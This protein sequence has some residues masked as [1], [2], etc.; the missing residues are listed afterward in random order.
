MSMGKRKT[1]PPP[2]EET[3]SYGLIEWLRMHRIGL[4]PVYLAVPVLIMGILANVAVEVMLLAICMT[5]W[6]LGAGA[7]V[8]TRVPEGWRRLHWLTIMVSIN[9]WVIW[10]ATLSTANGWMWALGLLASGTTILAIPHWMDQ[11]KRT[12]VN[13]EGLIRHWPVRGARIGLGDT[14]LV[15]ITHTAVGWVGKLSWQPGMH[16]IKKVEKIEHE[17][18][19]ALDLPHN[20]LKIERDG[21][22]NHS[23]ILQVTLNDPHA[24]GIM[25]SPA[26]EPTEDGPRLRT[27]H[28]GDPIKIGIRADGTEKF[29]RIFKAG[30]GARN[31]LIAGTKG[32]GKSGLLNLIWTTMALCDDVVQWGIDLKG[33]VE[34]GPWEGV[35]DW[36][37][38]DYASAIKMIEAAE[39]IVERRGQLLKKYGWKSWQGSPEHPWL[40]ISI[41]EAASLLGKMDSKQLF[42]VEEIARKGR[43]VGV[44]LAIATQYAT[45]DA[46]GSSQIREQLD[47]AF[48]FRQQ[49]GSGESFVITVGNVNAEEIDSERPGTCYHQ[50]G[51]KLDR[52]PM[53]I[54]FVGDGSNG[55]R[56]TVKLIADVMRGETPE[57][58][59]D[60]IRDGIEKLEAYANRQEVTEMRDD[61]EMSETAEGDEQVTGTE[62]ETETV[63]PFETDGS[64]TID[65]IQAA[66]RAAMT[67][68]ELA[69]DDARR[70]ATAAELAAEPERLS[71]ADAREA[72][73]T[74][75]REA[76]GA[77]L[78][79]EQLGAAA[80]RKKSWV[81]ERLSEHEEA[82]R[83]KRTSKGTWALTE[84]LAGS[85]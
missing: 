50:D 69:E 81:Y 41:D 39:Q 25:W 24:K 38:N 32:S 70:A 8:V 43:A 5:A 1:A 55:T 67:P 42:R 30:W 11:V 64:A 9:A 84:V 54:I 16:S 45:L 63:P 19:G 6:T 14:R 15:G 72:L 10:A 82:G 2:S 60:S 13:L 31:I 46:I 37:V 21:R 3:D 23:V 53:R 61:S 75:L 40:L 20:S 49:S 47:Q 62:T 34:L 44:A 33:G 17:I 4:A 18:E 35:F 85:N 58:D 68:E 83:V 66:A 29:L 7:W 59:A 71:D 36:I 73:L 77:G 12:R 80:T 79:Y 28:G 57:M 52:I 51:D 26:T 74:A 78:D 56:N 48:C 22:S 76:G 65:D 27:L